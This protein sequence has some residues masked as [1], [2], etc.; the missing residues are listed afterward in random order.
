MR[1]PADRRKSSA[2]GLRNDDL[3]L[4]PDSTPSVLD[5]SGMPPDGAAAAPESAERTIERARELPICPTC[6]IRL[7]DVVLLHEELH[8]LVVEMREYRRGLA[9]A[10]E[11][12]RAALAVDP[13]TV[14]CEACGE[15]IGTSVVPGY[16]I[17]CRPGG[18]S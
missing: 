6:G 15:E 9:A 2:G 12:T 13:L 14:R 18:G 7:M 3:T 5:T 17:R 1:R 8:D 4:P 11:R 16:C 10:L